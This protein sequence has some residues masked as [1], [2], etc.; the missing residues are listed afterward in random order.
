M[1]EL[2]GYHSNHMEITNISLKDKLFKSPNVFLFCFCF[3][4]LFLFLKVLMLNMTSYI[5]SK[6]TIPLVL[7][8]K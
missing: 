7:K 6:N 5:D 3:L 4:F 8:K 1:T 2:L